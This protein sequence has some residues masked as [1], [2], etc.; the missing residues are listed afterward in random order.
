[1]SMSSKNQ[2][3]N[4]FCAKK[5]IKREYS[6]ARTPQQNVIQLAFVLIEFWM[7]NTSK[8]KTPMIV[9]VM[10]DLPTSVSL[11]P[12]G[13]S[14]DYTE[15][16]SDQ[17]GKFDGTVEEAYLLG[18]STS[19]TAYARN[20]RARAA[21]PAKEVPLS[22]EEQALHDELMNL[23][24]QESL[25][26]AHNDDQRIAFEEDKE[27]ISIAEGKDT[28]NSTFILKWYFVST[29]SFDV[30]KR[31]S[32]YN[33]MGS[34]ID[35]P[36]LLLRLES[37]DSLISSNYWA[38]LLAEFK[39]E[40]LKEMRKWVE[41]MQEELLQ[42]SC[43]ERPSCTRYRQKEGGI[44]D[45]VFAQMVSRVHSYMGSR[46]T[47]ECMSNSLPGFE[48]P[49]SSKQKVTELY[50]AL[51]G[52]HQGS[53]EHVFYGEGFEELMR[54]EFKMSSMGEPHLLLGLQSKVTIA[55]FLGALERGGAH[56]KGEL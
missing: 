33:N 11:S 20:A 4:E 29:N 10:E 19:S 7:N 52:L 55:R 26:K 40:S 54:K 41:A 17:L 22:S 53:K 56:I 27:G 32:D 18:Y 14:S 47:E 1:M 5:G 12:F 37:R 15:Y 48:D 42:S 51:Y 46:S 30:R 43:R 2:L 44:D 31:S 25:A 3:M 45:E 21:S 38:K 49:E 28:V 9:D 6:I 24:H 35:V 23:M 39:Q 36:S 50:K 16:S 34:T 8:V 13:C